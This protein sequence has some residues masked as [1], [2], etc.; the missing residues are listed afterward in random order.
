MPHETGVCCLHAAEAHAP[1]ATHTHANTSIQAHTQMHMMFPQR[2]RT[3]SPSLPRFPYPYATTSQPG[4]RRDPLLLPAQLLTAPPRATPRT[5]RQAACRYCCAAAEAKPTTQ[6]PFASRPY[7]AERQPS[8]RC[9]PP[10]LRSCL[11]SPSCR[12]AMSGCALTHF[13]IGS[14]FSSISFRRV[15]FSLVIMGPKSLCGR[16]GGRGA[17]GWRRGRKGRQQQQQGWGVGGGVALNR[18]DGMGR[19]VGDGRRHTVGGR[20]AAVQCR[21]VS[22][23][24]EEVTHLSHHVSCEAPP[25][26]GA[27]AYT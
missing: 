16:R 18:V 17:A 20:G 7:P 24:C 6:Q 13:S 1:P 12:C 11:P 21:Q 15:L 26:M 2:P 14:I 22:G 27:V 25:E 19:V 9:R 3:V 5:T 4:Q 10:P 8:Y 23:M